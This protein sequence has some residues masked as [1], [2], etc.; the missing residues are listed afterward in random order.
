MLT[1][2]AI[3]SSGPKTATPPPDAARGATAD[4]CDV[5]LTDP[6]DI[7]TER[8]VQIMDPI[9]QNY[10]GNAR[11]KGQAATVKCYE[12][13]PL[14]RKALEEQ[15]DG[16]VLVVDGGGSK[17]C[18]LLGDNIAEMGH[19]NGW[20]GIIINGCIRDS[21]DINK[22]PLGVKALTT[23]PLK[24]SKRDLGLRDVPVTIAGVTVKAGDWIYADRDGVLVSAEELK[25]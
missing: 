2:S 24:S 22:M 17:R 15:G 18:A 25:V 3:A 12:N 4:L 16:R 1:T 8:K 20:T 6:V 14:V 11:F 9:F 23:Y 21:E 5:F 10:G 13:N 19:K 7:V